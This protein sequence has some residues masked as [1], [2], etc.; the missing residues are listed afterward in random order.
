MVT[1]VPIC[2][3]HSSCSSSLTHPLPLP[4]RGLSNPSFQT[5]GGPEMD[6]T[7]KARGRQGKLNQETDF[8]AK[9]FC[10]FPFLLPE[11]LPVRFIFT[12][13]KRQWNNASW[14][15]GLKLPCTPKYKHVQSE[16]DLLT[17]V[18]TTCPVQMGVLFQRGQSHLSIN[19]V[20]WW[21][22]R[23]LGGTEDRS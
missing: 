13:I 22:I 3:P 9:I 18:V 11:I 7:G 14:E 6:K 20:P 21:D 5:L 4:G 8:Q 16:C 12:I 10:L 15:S 23:V 17:V 19:K 2:L 1:T